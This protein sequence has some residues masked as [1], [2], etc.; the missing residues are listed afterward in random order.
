MSNPPY[1]AKSDE[2]LLK[3]REERNKKLAECDYTMLS[4]RELSESKLTEWKTYRQALRDLPKTETEPKIDE[5]NGSLI[6]V[7]WPTKPTE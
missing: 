3:M 2:I 5:K 1:T 4:D 6:N 7:T